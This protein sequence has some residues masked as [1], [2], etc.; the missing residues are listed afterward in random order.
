MRKQWEEIQMEYAHSIAKRSTDPKHQVGCVIVSEDNQRV[1]AIGYN[2][3]HKGG[4][5]ERLSMEHGKSGFIHA[6]NN[7]LI[8]LNPYENC[9]KIMYLTHSPCYACAQLIINAG[10]DNIIYK[11]EYSPDGIKLLIDSGVYIR[12]VDRHTPDNYVLKV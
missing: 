4:S 9:K 3:D 11:K 5:N 10:I 7:A 6:E 8:K 1:L 12:K 2:G